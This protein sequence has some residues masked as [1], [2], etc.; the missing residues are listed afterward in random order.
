[1]SI[2]LSALDV[3]FQAS[4][5]DTV[6]GAFQ[7]VDEAGAAT[8]AK[9]AGTIRFSA[10]NAAAV[11]ESINLAT[12]LLDEMGISAKSVADGLAVVAVA[13]RDLTN[14]NAILA[15]SGIEVE[16]VSKAQA[17]ALTEQA[18]AAERAAAAMRAAAAGGAGGGI[19]PPAGV[20]AGA[21]GAGEEAEGVAIADTVAG[22]RALTKQLLELVAA[23]EA[24]RAIRDAVVA[25]GTFDA[26]IESA[27]LGIAG[28]TQAYGTLTD[29]QG[30]TLRGQEA[31]TAAFAIADDQLT[32]LQADAIRVAVPFAQLADLFRGV[33]GA[34]L[35]AG[36]TLDQIR[37]LV[38]SAS[39]AA[40]ALGTPYEQLNTTLVQL[41]EGHVRVTN[42][43]VAHLGL[44][45]QI[46]HQWEQQGTLVEN[47][48]GTFGKFSAIGEQVQGT[49]RGISTEIKNAFDILAGAAVRPALTALEEGLRGALGQIVDLTTGK[50]QPALSGLV[51]AIGADLANIGKLFAEGFNAAIGFAK[52]LSGWLDRNQQAVAAVIGGVYALAEE[53]GVVVKSAIGLIAPLEGAY[54]QSG[55]VLVPIRAIGE[56]L[57]FAIDVVHGLA[58]ALSAAGFLF[59]NLILTPLDLF[60]EGL[61]KALNFIHAGLGDGL[62][63]AGKDGEAALARIAGPALQ[64]ISDIRT[65]NTAVQQ[66][67]RAW[68][69]AQIAAEHA[70]AGVRAAIASTSHALATFTPNLGGA[71]GGGKDAAASA[72]AAAQI[73]G[74]AAETQKAKLKAALDQNELS[75]KQYFDALTTV[76]IAA[77]DAQIR[78]KQ[79][80]LAAAE[81]PDDRAKI[82][83]EIAKLEEQEQAVRIR[84]AD[85]LATKQRENADK[86]I[87]DE[88]RLRAAQGDTYAAALANIGKLVEAHDAEMAKAG[89]SD[90]DRRTSNAELYDALVAQL[91]IKDKSQQVELGL[92]TLARQRLALEAAVRAGTMGEQDAEQRLA[93]LE[94]ARVPGLRQL[95]E[96]GLALAKALGDPAAIARMEQLDA[97]ITK[98]TNQSDALGRLKQAW[99]RTMAELLASATATAN[100]VAKKFSDALAGA[101]GQVTNPLQ[102][103]LDRAKQAAANV[104][105][106]FETLG[107]NIGMAIVNGLVS[108]VGKRGNFLGN[109]GTAIMAGIGG[110]FEQVGQALVQ[111]GV[112]MTGLAPLLSNPFTAGPAALGAGIALEILGKA[113]QAAF[114]G[115]SGGGGSAAVPSVGG[116]QTI[117]IALPGGVGPTTVPATQPPA[118]TSGA[119]SPVLP[120]GSLGSVLPAPHVALPPSG[121]LATAGAT[122][123]VSGNTFVGDWGPSVE[124]QIMKRIRLAE[125]RGL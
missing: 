87:A 54:I 43:L 100:A 27:R 115:S 44:S 4:G 103:Y 25:G 110:V 83:G 82:E 79:A 107:E 41:L 12:Q 16:A 29:A 23:Y 35:H 30:E 62:I 34:G 57:A 104:D 75:F 73:I 48:L 95:A 70:M 69:Q 1:M 31:L 74:A 42:Q 102:D 37:Q 72:E 61:G 90:A 112:I 63:E 99:D 67:G 56:G 58:A 85:E 47:L 2:D 13:D 49:W 40:T 3:T 18:A 97:E 46:V 36:A 55:L 19:V 6:L 105:Q 96:Q 68:D 21:G 118:V 101:G 52:D 7:Q 5:V 113:M 91:D 117:N 10:P 32:K 60:N 94:A 78:A 76:E 122:Y 111:Y 65:G 51:G 53:F 108:A 38:T 20:P 15:R 93:A 116:P 119:R 59:M 33:E 64:F 114:S 92:N 106:Q 84:N 50:I 89:A 71:A 98:A 121:S 125:R 26:T 120:S 39:L 123:V 28:I 77:L 80:A 86:L 22:Y 9:D 124:R 81:K 45:N 11:A 8:A 24:Y 88:Q 14:A 17:A 109:V 66:F